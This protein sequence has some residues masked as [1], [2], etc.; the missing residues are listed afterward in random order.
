MIDTVALREK[1]LDLAIRGKLVPQDPNDEPAS[2][3]LERIR[4]QKQQMVKE[5]KLKAKDIKDD[6][7]IF[8]GDDNLHYEKF[9]DGTVKCIK[10]EIP[11]ELPEGW[12]WSRLQSF[13]FPITDGTHQTP[14]YSDEGYVF[15]S[16]KNVTKGKID[17]DNVMH[18]PES[19]HKELYAR[20]APRKN[21]ILLAKNGTVGVAAIVDRDCIFDIY[22]TLAVLRTIS[23]GIVPQYLL[24][25]ILSSTVQAFFKS[26]LIGIGVQNLHLE[27][28]RKTPVPIPPTREQKAIANQANLLEPYILQVDEQKNKLYADLR[29]IKS[30]ILDLAIQG[31]LVPQ[32]PTDEPASVLLER[33]RA[34]K[35]E[36]IK[37]GKIKRDKKESII[38][39]GDDNSYYEKF[40]DGTVKCI[41]DEIS[42][43]LPQGWSWCR[44]RELF[45]VCSAKR[46]LQ[47]EWKSEGIPFYRAREIVKL[48]E[49][50][51]VDNDLFI[52][53]EH[54]DKLR[55]TYGVPQAS[56]LMVTGV[57][58]IG[59]VYIV[60]EDDVFYYKDASVLCFENRYGA[61]NSEFAQIMLG[62]SFL[63]G[64]IHSQT[65]GNTVDTI[66]ISTAN[67]YL[68]ILPPLSE[69]ARII[70]MFNKVSAIVSNAEKS[71]N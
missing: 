33:I 46:V 16:A 9:A 71:L 67:N 34:E 12:A 27:H 26:S 37:Q 23:E 53:P 2:V 55:K 3:L 64:Q 14:T 69:Q 58:T 59:K 41:E 1:V 52:S 50:G 47:S 18:I 31:K 51:F 56:D 15:L 30:K 42:F 20:I 24:T 49:K 29:H 22:V 13:C 57:G 7:V 40:D 63:Q 66:T 39:K 6:S 45:N 61:I 60:R 62:S 54:Y 25:A 21:D 32:D 5:G 11:F 8:V 17:W 35:E 68:C 19:L 38:F 10:D 65:Y 48:S 44:L 28:I 70:N 4:E 43:E 36:L